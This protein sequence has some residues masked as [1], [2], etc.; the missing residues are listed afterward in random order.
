MEEYS[1]LMEFIQAIETGLITVTLSE[2]NMLPGTFLTYWK[3]YKHQVAEI[4]EHQ[5]K[6]RNSQL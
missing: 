3:I 6:T 5:K 4:R 2:Y 1:E